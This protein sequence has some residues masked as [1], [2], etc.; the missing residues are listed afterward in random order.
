MPHQQHTATTGDTTAD[1]SRLAAFGDHL[2]ALHDELRRDIAALREAAAQL[3]ADGD[4]PGPLVLPQRLHSHCLSFCEALDA[5]HTTE[6]QSVF[7]FL[8]QEHPEL[9]EVLDRLTSDHRTMATL[10]AGLRELA[11]APSAP[12]FHADL[13]R[14]SVELLNHLD[15][16]EHYLV[17]VLN[18]LT[19]FPGH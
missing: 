18:S 8:A 2:I 14:L 3:P 13:E 4:A 19:H 15:R 6:D 5:H 1:H 17:P 11:A 16:E 12:G 9:S 7:P 10:L